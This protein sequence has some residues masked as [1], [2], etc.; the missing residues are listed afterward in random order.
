M[1]NRLVDSKPDLERLSAHLQCCM[2]VVFSLVEMN[3]DLSILIS[4]QFGDEFLSEYADH[5]DGKRDYPGL[6][7]P[8]F[9]YSQKSFDSMQA[10]G[11]YVGP[12]VAL[13]LSEEFDPRAE[14]GLIKHPLRAVQESFEALGIKTSMAIGG[15]FPNEDNLSALVFD[16]SDPEFLQ[17]LKPRFLTVFPEHESK[18]LG[19]PWLIEGAEEYRAYIAGVL[20]ALR[21]LGDETE[22][23]FGDDKSDFIEVSSALVDIKTSMVTASRAVES[24][25]KYLM[26]FVSKAYKPM[27][28]LLTPNE[29]AQ[30]LR[31]TAQKFLGLAAPQ[32]QAQVHSIP[33]LEF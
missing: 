16:T 6:A 20:K 28:L 29:R 2:G 5:L 10:A 17:K 27:A 19:H 32:A 12:A 25:I 31:D 1:S 3:A 30:V 8:G 33:R 21:K 4:G 9:G 23:D 18:S 7:S 15:H 11:F 13:I 24:Q 22:A 26:N 14:E